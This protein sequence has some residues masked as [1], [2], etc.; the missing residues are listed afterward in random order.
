MYWKWT[1]DKDDTIK[2]QSVNSVL[3]LEGVNV[4]HFIDQTILKG[5]VATCSLL[6]H[7]VS[8]YHF[9]E[10]DLA[11]IVSEEL[12]LNLF[13]SITELLQPFVRNADQKVF[14]VNFQASVM[15]KGT[16]A[17]DRDR[18]F[19]R[20]INSKISNIIDLAEPNIL[21]GVTAGGKHN[22][23]EQKLLIMFYSYT[24]IVVASWR[25]FMKLPFSSFVVYMDMPD[26]DKTSAGPILDLISKLGV[27]CDSTFK[28]R[29]SAVNESNLYT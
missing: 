3:I 26:F 23:M 24:F 12:D 29:I 14:T 22:C 27:Q 7:K 4:L 11:I 18:C 2:L 10:Q 6:P 13:G 15:H 9:A 25:K 5:K 28:T 17:E 19:I 8:V 1:E 20:S 16:P 21:T